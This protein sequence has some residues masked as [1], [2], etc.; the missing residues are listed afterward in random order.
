MALLDAAAQALVGALGGVVFYLL[1]IPGVA[2]LHFQGR[3]FAWTELWLGPSRLLLV[4]AGVLTLAVL[5]AAL[6]LT[7]IIISPLGVARRITPRRLSLVRVVV[8]LPLLLLWAPT[9]RNIDLANL[10]P[11][12]VVFGLCFGVLSLVGPLVLNVVGRIQVRRA[13]TAGSLL[14]ARRLLDDPRGACA[15]LAG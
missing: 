5:S 12:L 6:G 11:V 3:A 15:P 14:A 2:L 9:V 1:A 8:A 7:R 13:G 4:L 10:L